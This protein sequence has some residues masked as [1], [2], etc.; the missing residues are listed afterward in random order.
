MAESHHVKFE[1]SPP[2]AFVDIV[3]FNNLFVC[4]CVCVHVNNVGHFLMLCFFLPLLILSR[5]ISHILY[6]NKYFSRCLISSHRACL[7]LPN[8]LG[9]LFPVVNNRKC[10]EFK[11]L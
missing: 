3:F 11:M 2:L 8:H 10:Y 4:V 7:H 6:F 9:H 1:E 5:A